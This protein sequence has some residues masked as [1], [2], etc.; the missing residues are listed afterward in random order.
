MTTSRST[1]TAMMMEQTWI[2]TEIYDNGA[3]NFQGAFY[4]L[5]MKNDY[6]C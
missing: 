2:N 5:W 4:L 6:L 1:Q 3:L